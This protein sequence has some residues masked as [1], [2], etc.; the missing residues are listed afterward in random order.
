MALVR[1]NPW[2]DLS[3]LHSQMDRLFT[4]SLGE[5][6]DRLASEYSSLPVDIQQSDEQF[7]I[8]ASVPGFKPE[9]VEVTFDEGVLT[10][11]G[12]HQDETDGPTGQWVRR[13][14]R[15]SSMHR[16]LALPAEVQVDKIAA[17]FE[18]GVL[19]I[20]VPRAQ[21]AQPKRI[22]VSATSTPAHRVIEGTS[23]DK[24]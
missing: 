17:G 7:T 2:S 12:H 10:I 6:T 3:S 14:R 16:Q 1:W 4:E 22:P 20:T 9:D 23:S 11:R 15:M 19:T 21:K 18:N 5:V 24:G 13:E 8:V